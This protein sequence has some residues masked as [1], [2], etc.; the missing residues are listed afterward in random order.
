MREWEKESG[1]EREAD[2]GEAERGSGGWQRWIRFISRWEALAFPASDDLLGYNVVTHDLSLPTRRLATTPYLDTMATYASGPCVQRE[3]LSTL[4]LCFSRFLIVL[5]SF[6]S[7]F[8][9]SRV[10][11]R[12]F[13][14][15]VSGRREREKGGWRLSWPRCRGIYR[16]SCNQWYNL[17]S[18]YK[19]K[20]KNIFFV[21]VVGINKNWI[22][23]KYT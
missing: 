18:T 11:E 5:S 16:V 19:Y 17:D 22:F 14:C 1:I 2:R 20:M 4:F 7:L 13:G 23:F 9:L 3:E 21:R 8:S 10:L 12:V 6:L 15:G